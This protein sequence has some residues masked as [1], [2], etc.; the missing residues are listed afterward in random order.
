ML[1]PPA[2]AAVMVAFRPLFDHRVFERATVLVADAVLAVRTRTVGDGTSP[3]AALRVTG[4]DDKRFSAYHR[5]RARWSRLGAAR[6]LLGLAADRFAP[7]G[8][9]VVGCDDAAE[10]S[11][12]IRAAL[13]TTD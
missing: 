7:D 9:V 11:S 10:V 8:P 13:G 3:F 12:A 6:I 4:H 1:L 5:V 2:L